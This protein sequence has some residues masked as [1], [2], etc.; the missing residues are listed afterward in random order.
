MEQN[1]EGR[2]PRERRTQKGKS[3]TSEETGASTSSR[4]ETVH[5][6]HYGL[7]FCL[8]LLL[9]FVSE[10][11]ISQSDRN[12]IFNCIIIINW[13]VK[14]A[15][16]DPQHP[17][18]SSLQMKVPLQ[19]SLRLTNIW[20]WEESSQPNKIPTPRC[21]HW[22]CSLPMKWLLSPN[23]GITWEDNWKQSQL[24]GRSSQL[25]KSSKEDPT[26]SRLTASCWDINQEPVSTTC[27]RSSETSPSTEPSVNFTWRWL[28]T[29][30]PLV[31]PFRSLELLS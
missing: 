18:D 13:M 5:G 11:I 15:R 29:T 23:S 14:I 4:Q 3:E 26:M 28:V 2:H 10:N 17:T 19:L 7:L 22:D 16:K 8:I 1:C 25:T 6:L 30:E 20:L 24:K 21:T 31:T 9:T 12:W 27:T